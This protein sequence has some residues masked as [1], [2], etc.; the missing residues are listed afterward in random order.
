M[1]RFGVAK[2]PELSP[3]FCTSIPPGRTS[4]STGSAARAED[5]V[6]VEASAASLRR[7]LKFSLRF[8]TPAIRMHEL[9]TQ[10]LEEASLCGTKLGSMHWWKRRNN[11][12][13]WD[14]EW[15][16][17]RH[18]WRDGWV[19]VTAKEGREGLPTNEGNIVVKK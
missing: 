19:A 2:S 17:K 16:G 13:G 6:V 9:K 11:G 18:W 8:I 4:H 10:K 3:L 7:P 1:R 5:E 14:L 15:M 12:N